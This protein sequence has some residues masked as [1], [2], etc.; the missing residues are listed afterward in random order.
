MSDPNKALLAPNFM[1]PV[2]GSLLI[3]VV[4]ETHMVDL[5][6]GYMF[7]SFRT[8]LVF[9]KY[10]GVY[11]GTYLLYDKN[12]GTPYWLCWVL[13]M[14]G[15]ILYPYSSV[16]GVLWSSKAVQVYMSDPDNLFRWDSFGINL[17]GDIN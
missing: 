15:L 17:T 9:Y 7:Y 10:C 13:P 3:M 4:P 12:S 11:L 1:L 2:L 6:M 16:N 8:Y 14:T 5:D